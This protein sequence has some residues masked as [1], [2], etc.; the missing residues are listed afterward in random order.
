MLMTMLDN[1]H[2]L[3]TKLEELW[4]LSV[5]SAVHRRPLEWLYISMKILHPFFIRLLIVNLLTYHCNDDIALS[6]VGTS[7]SKDSR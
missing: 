6:V 4:S 3:C 5:S 7:S 2:I 1:D